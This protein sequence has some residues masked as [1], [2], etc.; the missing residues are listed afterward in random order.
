MAK[1]RLKKIGQSC[2][3]K[4]CRLEFRNDIVKGVSE[5]VA[6]PHEVNFTQGTITCLYC[7]KVTKFK[8]K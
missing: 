8:I 7:G 1:D 4:Q 3:S 5:A 2:D 6:T